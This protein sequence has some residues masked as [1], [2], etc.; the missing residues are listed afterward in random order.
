MTSQRTDF[1][2]K[3]KK[4]SV[5][6]LANVIDITV[7]KKNGK[8]YFAE[9]DVLQVSVLALNLKSCDIIFEL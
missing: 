9:K 3:Q 4:S 1:H 6:L 2:N 5:D 8:V 7:G